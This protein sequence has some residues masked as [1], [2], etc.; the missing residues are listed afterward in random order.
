MESLGVKFLT[1]KKEEE[2]AAQGKNKKRGRQAA[3]LP[4][5]PIQS[6]MFRSPIGM[7]DELSV[8]ANRSTALLL[9]P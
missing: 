1:R 5:S 2:L 3:N 4:Q 9:S 6:E 8:D 7:G